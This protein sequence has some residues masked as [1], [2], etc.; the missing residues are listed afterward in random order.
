MLRFA[1]RRAVTHASPAVSVRY[2]MHQ[3]QSTAEDDLTWLEG[4]KKM[5]PEERWALQRQR[6][7]LKKSAAEINTKYEAEHQ[8]T[9]DAMENNSNQTAA[10][11][12]DLE[13]KIE[14][15]MAAIAALK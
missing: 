12:T 5:T 11:I 10:K 9:R 1:T 4:D 3:S 6:E 15:L 2:S 13:N 14:E 7:L 8:K